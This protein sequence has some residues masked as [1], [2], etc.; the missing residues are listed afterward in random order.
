MKPIRG[1]SGQA[2]VRWTADTEQ[3]AVEVLKEE[4]Q[5]RSWSKLPAGGDLEAEGVR[6]G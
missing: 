2:E 4:W 5:R 1:D 3:A 6:L